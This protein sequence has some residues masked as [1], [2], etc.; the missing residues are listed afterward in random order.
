MKTKIQKALTSRGAISIYSSI[1]SILIGL[2]FG[3]LL[4]LIVNPERSS[5]GIQQVLLTGVLSP[6]KFAKVLYQAAPLIFTGLSV[7]F[8]FKTGLFNIGATGQYTI[9]AFLAIFTGAVL[10][11]P[12]WAA[13]LAAMLGGALWGFFPGICKALFN[14]NEVITSIMFNWIGL[15]LANLLMANIPQILANFY[16]ASNGDRTANLEAANPAAMIPKLGLDEL[17]N[18]T[19]MNISIMIAIAVAAIIFIILNRTTFGYELKACG[20]NRNASVYAGINA[21]RNIVLSMAIS[22]ALAGIGGGIYYLSGTA[23]YTIVKSLLPMGFNGIPVA[24]LAVSH[25]LG[26]IFSALF[27]SYIQ[28]G[29]EAMQPEYAKEVIDIIISVIIYLSAFSLILQG[30]IRR[31]LKRRDEKAA[32]AAVGGPVIA[33]A[34]GP[35]DAVAKDSK[36]PPASDE[37]SSEA[38]Q[39]DNSEEVT[40]A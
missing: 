40:K 1:F 35:A 8:A 14:V 18:S 22:G 3:Y 20:F 6:E 4:L 37:P 23:Q 25:P 34:A 11:M 38:S 33:D 15:F 21:K 30:V 36:E 31:L 12:W 7:A 5:Y 28:V 10:K 29:G 16:G 2:V 19:Y 32:A 17:F 9:G 27:I 39:P 13:L 24:L 26:V